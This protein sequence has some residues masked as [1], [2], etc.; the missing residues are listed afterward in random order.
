MGESSGRG[1]SGSRNAPVVLKRTI[2]EMKL[3]IKTEVLDYEGKPIK[4][5][6]TENLVWRTVVFNALNSVVPN[7]V[8]TGEQKARCYRITQKIYDSNEPDLTVEERS[9]VLERIEKVFNS[10]LICG[11]SKEFFEEK[12]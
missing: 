5:S 11:K 6:D 7:E 2:T 3:K 10:P 4:V 1:S 8:L 12:Q 9:F